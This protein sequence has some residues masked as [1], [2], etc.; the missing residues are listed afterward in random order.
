MLD[1]TVTQ[2]FLETFLV[3]TK[4][5]STVNQHN[6]LFNNLVRIDSFD[7]SK[8]NFSFISVL[9]LKFRGCSADE[10]ICSLI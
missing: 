5:K 1:L 4:K 7:S 9:H 10:N 6:S 2:C 8:L 3:F